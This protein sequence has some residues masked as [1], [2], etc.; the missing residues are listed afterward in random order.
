[1]GGVGVLNG[2]DRWA[3][4]RRRFYVLAGGGS[5][6]LLS[7]TTVTV[8]NRSRWHLACS[9]RFQGALTMRVLALVLSLLDMPAAAN[10][11]GN[12]S[13]YLFLNPAK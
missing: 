6:L 4:G 13:V 3:T 10:P 11:P 7:M 9:G 2:A 12:A 1:M 5:R 8:A